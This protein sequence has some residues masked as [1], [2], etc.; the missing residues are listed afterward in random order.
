MHNSQSVARVE[1]TPITQWVSQLILS[2]LPNSTSCANKVV[3]EI[4]EIKSKDS[5]MI[6]SYSNYYHPY[7]LTT[8][9]ENIAYQISY[10]ARNYL[11][12]F[13]TNFSPFEP[14]RRR[15]GHQNNQNPSL[16]GQ[17]STSSAT[18]ST[19][20][21]DDGESSSESDYIEPETSEH[22]SFLPDPPAPLSF[23]SL[24]PPMQE[25]YGTTITTPNK[26]AMEIY[27]RYN[28]FHKSSTKTLQ[29]LTID[30]TKAPQDVCIVSNA[31]QYGKDCSR[32]VELKPLSDESMK[33]YANYVNSVDHILHG[34][35]DS[36]TSEQI[37]Q[38]VNFQ[39]KKNM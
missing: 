14:G 13:R 28:D 1:S 22:D 4:I 26:N 39:I 5:E 32:E 18:S 9:D 35:S 38:Y 31:D 20:S 2:Y 8:F 29:P 10:W 6:D 11:P 7:K 34:K 12:T 36:K 23:S 24:L 21:S 30:D 17:S 27:K 16:T 37:L 19:S 3:R 25:I 33:I 15:D